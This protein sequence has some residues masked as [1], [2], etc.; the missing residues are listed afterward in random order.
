MCAPRVR[1][2]VVGVGS[3]GRNLARNFEALGCLAGLCDSNSR[4]LAGIAPLYPRVRAFDRTA[5]LMASG[6]IDA[7][8]IATPAATHAPIASRALAAGLHVFVEKPMTTE[9][10]AARA[11]AAQ[12]EAT[13]L[14]LVTGHLLHYHPAFQTLRAL[15]N[16]GM[17]GTV[18]RIVAQRLVPGPEVPREHVLWEFAPHDIAMILSLAGTMPRTVTC[19]HWGENA[20]QAPGSSAKVELT[21][22]PD[23]WTEVQVSWRSSSKVQLLKVCGDKASVAF[24]DVASHGSKLMLG[25]SDGSAEAVTYPEQEPLACECTAF[26]EAVRTG[27]PPLSGASEGLRVM[28]VLDACFRSLGR[29]RSVALASQGRKT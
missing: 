8:A 3:W 29:Q 15:V 25:R 9:L 2:G 14:Q 5:D 18:H 12:A 27:I 13:G 7:I 17:L 1:V 23:L 4:A 28:T 10:A 24:D 6:M 21:F 11:L 26:I 20:C 19:T 16:E 22:G